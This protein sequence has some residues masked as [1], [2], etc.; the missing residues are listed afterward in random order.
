MVGVEGDV[1]EAKPSG[2]VRDC[3]SVKVADWVMNFNRCIGNDSTGGI[4]DSAAKGCRVRLRVGMKA[5]GQIENHHK[6]RMKRLLVRSQHEFLLKI[7]EPG[8]TSRAEK[9]G[10]ILGCKSLG[11]RRRTDTK[12][13]DE[14]KRVVGSHWRYGQNGA[15]KERD[16]TIHRAAENP[17]MSHGADRTL[18]VGKLGIVSVNVDGLDDAGESDQQDA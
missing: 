10:S 17:G 15:Y 9:P 11:R 8:L 13:G 2:T 18:M 12:T 5:L 7:R 4:Q 1:R 3:R 16:R 6:S 14:A